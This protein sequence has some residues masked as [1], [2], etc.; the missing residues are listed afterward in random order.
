[1]TIGETTPRRPARTGRPWL[2]RW[3]RRLHPQ[4]LALRL[5]PRTLYAR[6]TLAIVVPMLLLQML[7]TW[8]FYDRLWDGVTGIMARTLVGDIK[9]IIAAHEDREHPERYDWIVRRA[10]A[11]MD[12]T[13][14][15]WKDERIP[16]QPAA[17]RFDI[18]QREL[19]WTLYRDLNRPSYIDLRSEGT[20]VLVTVQLDEG[21]LYVNAPLSRLYTG[22]SWYFV[23]ATV[24][25]A[26]VL[27]GLSILFI[28]HELRP[29]RRL[30][31]IADMLGKGRDVPD[32][33]PEGALEARRAASAFLT[34]RDRIRRQVEQRTDM[35]S[36][37]SHDL[38]TPLTRMKLGLAMM[39][40]GPE[41]RELEA[42]V[43]AM[44]H[45]IDGYLAFARGEGDEEAVR[46]DLAALLESVC[47][48]ARR[49][50]RDVAMSFE[51][52]PHAIVRRMA[53]RRGVENLVANALR[54]GHHVELRGRRDGPVIDLTVDD[55]GP[56][57][58]TNRRDE[59]FR[60]FFRLDSSRNART[61]GVGLGLT[62]ARDVARAHGGDII[63]E[64]SPLGGLRAHLRLPV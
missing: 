50:G 49:E 55:D 36:G 45:M 1:M 53:I 28:R 31:G 27:F 26:L 12:L 47:A 10:A 41:R 21:V 3:L 9:L 57:I 40:E 14:A 33:H 19:G 61:G 24:G 7:T 58:P 5:Y 59:V 30:A 56:G 64:T 54:H 52:E 11:D 8:L 29:I 22:S 62:I 6:A 25:S 16:P 4:R 15:Y 38:R 13:V 42:D 2:G 63:L 34:M 32:I 39:E 35:L 20:R 23:V 18:V 44:A 46:T 17:R 43:E 51:G 48:D 60:P 37:V